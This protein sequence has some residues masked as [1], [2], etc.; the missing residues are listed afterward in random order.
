[1][2]SPLA[3]PPSLSLSGAPDHVWAALQTS[4]R[5]NKKELSAT[6][7][8]RPFVWSSVFETTFNPLCFQK[9]KGPVF[10]ILTNS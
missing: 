9:T 6:L 3:L 5:L 7:K 1:M 8:E 4:E 10:L 2:V